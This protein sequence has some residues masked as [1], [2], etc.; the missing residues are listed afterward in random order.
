MTKR[1][2][3]RADHGKLV[4]SLGDFLLRSLDPLADQRMQEADRASRSLDC[5]PM[6]ITVEEACVQ[7]EDPDE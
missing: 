4:L 5:P 7:E 1:G 2:L 6:W 3:L